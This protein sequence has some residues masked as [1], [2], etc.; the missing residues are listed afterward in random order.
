M[1]RFFNIRQWAG[2]MF[3]LSLAL[4]APS[5]AAFSMLV[6]GESWQDITMGTQKFHY[7][8]YPSSSWVIHSNDFA[9][10]PQNL[11]EE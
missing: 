6:P 2:W 8:T 1:S 7:I 11:G 3:G 4:V 10:H 9:C 5:A